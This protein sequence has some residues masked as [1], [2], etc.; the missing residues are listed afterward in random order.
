[1]NKLIQLYPNEDYFG[2]EHGDEHV[3]W[4]YA[5]PSQ[6]KIFENAPWLICSEVTTKTSVDDTPGVDFHISGKD[7][8]AAF[9]ILNNKLL[10]LISGAED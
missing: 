9:L 6:I 2:F 5:N 10:E 8:S 7:D 1:M 3:T 4:V